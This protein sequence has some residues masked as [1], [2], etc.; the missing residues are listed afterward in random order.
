MAAS[1]FIFAA[2][3][4]LVLLQVAA[5]IRESHCNGVKIPFDTRF[6]IVVFPIGCPDLALELQQ[7][8]EPICVIPLCFTTQCLR[9]HQS[10]VAQS[11]CFVVQLH[12]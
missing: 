12:S 9:I 7:F 2:I 3:A 4:C 6:K 10:G 1:R 5:E 11:P 8:V